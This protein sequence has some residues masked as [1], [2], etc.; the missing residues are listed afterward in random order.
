MLE[1]NPEN[2]SLIIRPSSVV[3]SY[4]LSLRLLT[5][6]WPPQTDTRRFAFM[7]ETQQINVCFSGHVMRNY[8]V[9][10]TTS[11]YVIELNTAVSPGHPNTDRK[12]WIY[13]EQ[14]QETE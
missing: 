12:G 9:S 1:A 3:N 11:G 10:A 8:R 7:Q 14:K 4:A 2:G 5:P 13:G 6:R